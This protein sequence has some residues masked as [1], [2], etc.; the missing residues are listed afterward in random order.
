[1][2][3]S[4]RPSG[5]GDVLHGEGCM[6]IVEV[7]ER[8]KVR[9]DFSPAGEFVPIRF[10]RGNEDFRVIRVNSTWED[11]REDNRH[12]YF[13]VNV[14]ECDDVFQLCYRERDRTW[15]LDCVMLDG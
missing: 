5:P 8:I 14:E 15:L 7:K 3:R 4:Q 11:R 2:I 12:V 6:Q 1:M 13:S 9:A 10:K